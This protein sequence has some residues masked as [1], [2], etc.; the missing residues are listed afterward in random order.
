[1]FHG[2]CDGLGLNRFIEAVLYHYFCLRDGRKYSG[3]G[4]YTERIP[5]DPAEETNIHSSCIRSWEFSECEHDGRQAPVS[6][7][8][9]SIPRQGCPGELLFC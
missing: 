3:E 2:L 6:I 4:I 5:Y 9:L 1:M 7:F 8:L